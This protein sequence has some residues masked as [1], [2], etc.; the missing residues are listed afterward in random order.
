MAAADKIRRNGR[1]EEGEF[2]F[3]DLLEVDYICAIKAKN[4]SKE[5]LNLL[6][7]AQGYERKT[8]LSPLCWVVGIITVALVNVI[9]WSGEMLYIVILGGLDLW[10]VVFFCVVYWYMLKNDPDRLHSEKFILE[11]QKLTLEAEKNKKPVITDGSFDIT[12]TD[13]KE[14][15]Q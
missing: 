5:G 4:M 3:V 1:D 8:A 6:K 13:Y 12:E 10:A 15:E 9:I 2:F 11:R 7:F 14:V